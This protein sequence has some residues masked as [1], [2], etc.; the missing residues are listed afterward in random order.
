MSQHIEYLCD[1]TRNIPKHNADYRVTVQSST[2]ENGE[3]DPTL[4]TFDACH[5]CLG[6]LI[7]DLAKY[8]GLKETKLVVIQDAQFQ[9]RPRGPRGERKKERNAEG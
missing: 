5:E 8:H 1:T 3:N 6:E 9:P 4:R 7:R 2:K